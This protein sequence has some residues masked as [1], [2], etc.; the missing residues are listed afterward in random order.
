[1]VI[2][3]HSLGSLWQEKMLPAGGV[4]IW[5][6]TGIRDGPRVRSCAKVFGQ[7]KFGA[8]ARTELSGSRSITGA[9]WSAS[10]SAGL[11]HVRK[12][13]LL[14]RAPQGV[15][16]ELY[17]VTVSESLVGQLD[18]DSFDV[19]RTALISFS[20]WR[21]RQEVMLLMQPFAWL[22]GSAGSAVLVVNAGN[23][24]WEVTRW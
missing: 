24:E 19:S 5:N 2:F 6:T 4:R 10:G 12:L 21:S 15:T 22:R 17:L 9:S 1:M 8:R 23:C 3:V 20:R 11:D 7:V 13:A 14:C 16:P 18:Q